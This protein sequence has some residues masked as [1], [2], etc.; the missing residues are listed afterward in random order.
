MG[1]NFIQALEPAL[2]QLLEAAGLVQRHF[3]GPAAPDQESGL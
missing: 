1:G 3:F 2:T